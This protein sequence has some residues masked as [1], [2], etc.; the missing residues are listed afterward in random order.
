MYEGGRTRSP[1]AFQFKRQK[2]CMSTYPL[3]PLALDLSLSSLFLA[4]ICRV[5][6]RMRRSGEIA[7]LASVQTVACRTDGSGK[8]YAKLP[9]ITSSDGVCPLLHSILVDDLDCRE[10]TEITGG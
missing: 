1:L 7:Y 4:F 5:M 9:F 10:L 6:R 3:N 8:C 2:I